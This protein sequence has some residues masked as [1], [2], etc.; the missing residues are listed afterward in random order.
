[1]DRPS[2]VSVVS[3]AATAA[4]KCRVIG[5]ACNRRLKC[6]AKDKCVHEA[7]AHFPDG[8]RALEK[9]SKT[10]DTRKG[11][12]LMSVARLPPYPPTLDM[13]SSSPDIPSATTP[14][15]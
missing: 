14:V 2:G 9:L 5:N 4:T 15:K 1:M 6:S 7:C 10:Q 8:I 13:I 11:A 12:V 3:V